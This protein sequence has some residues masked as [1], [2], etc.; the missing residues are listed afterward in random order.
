[1]L[2]CRKPQL[3]VRQDFTGGF[4]INFGNDIYNLNLVKS[5]I[6]F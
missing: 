2:L 5:E 6:I 1:M 3:A 4:N